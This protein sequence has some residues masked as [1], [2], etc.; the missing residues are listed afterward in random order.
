M[1]TGVSGR[2]RIVDELLQDEDPAIRWRTRALAL[3]EDPESDVVRRLADEIRESPRVRALLAHRDASGRIT[4]GRN[5]YAKWQGAHW[6][7]AH[8]AD[9]GYPPGDETLFP[10]RDQ[11][12]D[13]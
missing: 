1:P 4:S 3:G 2:T 8:L 5:V 10:V 13:H 9:L 11:I 12:L 7:L 6:I